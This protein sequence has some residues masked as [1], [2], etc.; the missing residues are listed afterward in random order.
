MAYENW[1]WATEAPKWKDVWEIVD[2]VN[3]PNIGLCLDTFQTAGGE[4]GDPTTDSGLI[5]CDGG[6]EAL[7]KQFEASLR[8]LS[9]IIPPEKIYILQ[10]SDAY[11]PQRPLDSKPDSNGLRP[12]GQ[13]SSTL[14][15]I[16]FSNGY[17]PVVRVATAVLRTGFRGWFSMEVFDAGPE[18]TGREWNDMPEFAQ[19]AMRA[20]QQLLEHSGQLLRQVR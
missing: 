16:P 12:R 4:W 8:A 6:R 11:K 10:I 20:H 7:E 19:E 14:R 17:L 1:C 18:G 3:R 5:E 2:Q 15:P 9:A 13:W